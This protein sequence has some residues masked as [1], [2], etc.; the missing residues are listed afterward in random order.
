MFSNANKGVDFIK[1]RNIISDSI[2]NDAKNKEK[3]ESSRSE[4]QR[5]EDN[6]RNNIKNRNISSY[7][8]R[9]DVNEAETRREDILP[10][11][12]EI[13]KGGLDKEFS[14]FWV[15][16]EEFEKKDNDASSIMK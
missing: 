10:Q 13:T 14:K 8:E 7:D 15:Y 16:V 4:H 1:G 2:K 6:K 9:V 12:F 3:E 11:L 5:D